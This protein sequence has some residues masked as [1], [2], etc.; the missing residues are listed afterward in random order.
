VASEVGKDPPLVL[1]KAPHR[2]GTATRGGLRLTLSMPIDDGA[3]W[4][5]PGLSSTKLRQ[6]AH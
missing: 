4:G 2:L 5:Q 3:N 6:F 1:R